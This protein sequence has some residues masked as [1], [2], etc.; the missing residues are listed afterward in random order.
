MPVDCTR[1]WKNLP[2]AQRRKLDA[3]IC[4]INPKVT[5]SWK[6]RPNREKLPETQDTIFKI[7]FLPHFRE[8]N[9]TAILYHII[10]IRECI[11]KISHH[12]ADIAELTIDS[13]YKLE[14]IIEFARWFIPKMVKKGFKSVFTFLGSIRTY[15]MSRIKDAHEHT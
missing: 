1:L 6:S 8:P 12:T 13:T 4:S 3:L 7:T 11:L 9:D 2:P 10:N 5:V 14:N 15:L